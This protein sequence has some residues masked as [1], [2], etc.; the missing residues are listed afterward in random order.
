MDTL[1]LIRSLRMT[2]HVQSGSAALMRRYTGLAI[3]TLSLISLWASLSGCT[4]QDSIPTPTA[5]ETP[6]P[7]AGG[8]PDA[9]NTGIPAGTKLIVVTGNQTYWTAG[10]VI[11]GK[12]IRGCVEIKAANITIKNSKISCDNSYVVYNEANAS[13]VIEDSEVTCNNGPG[14]GLG[15][16]NITARRVNVHGCENGFNVAVNVSLTDSFIHDLWADS[17]AHSDGL[18]LAIGNDVTIKH[19]VIEA[20]SNG[21]SAIISPSTGT[22]NVL[23]QN[24]LMSGGAATVYCRQKGAGDNYQVIDNRISRKFY[25]TGGAYMPWTECEDEAVVTGNVWDDTG[26]PLPF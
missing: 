20:G 17:A 16:A 8:F 18:Q 6:T 22:K 9:S 25:P 19:N 1:R 2:S 11:D 23:I 13:F 15:D 7:A 14:T 24:N 5:S 12:D 21:T 10:Q 3:V 26:A 4:A